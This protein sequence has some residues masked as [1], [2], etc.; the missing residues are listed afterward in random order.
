MSFC[1]HQD[2]ST[3]KV[4]MDY[5]EPSLNCSNVVQLCVD[6]ASSL[7]T[8]WA[9]WWKWRLTAG[10]LD[11]TSTPLS[12]QS[13]VLCSVSITFKGSHKVTL[14]QGWS[15]D[16]IL[17]SIS[18]D[19]VFSSDGDGSATELPNQDTVFL[20]MTQNTEFSIFFFFF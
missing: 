10:R 6:T 20:K 15:H 12:F 16:S 7:C 14:Q 8:V 3:L 18:F 5:T 4:I 1:P 13:D 2:V 9:T 17:F 19:S 11:L